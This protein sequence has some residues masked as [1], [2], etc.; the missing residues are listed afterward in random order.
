[1]QPSDDSNTGNLLLLREPGKQNLIQI[2][3]G[4]RG[5]PVRAVKHRHL[6]RQHSG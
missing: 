6:G 2:P 1:M 3:C 4:H 5:L